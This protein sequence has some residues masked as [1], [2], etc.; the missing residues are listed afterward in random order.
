MGMFWLALS[1][2]LIIELDEW[3]QRHRKQQATPPA[4]PQDEGKDD[5]SLDNPRLP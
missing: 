4:D 2:L 5:S 1:L 3:W